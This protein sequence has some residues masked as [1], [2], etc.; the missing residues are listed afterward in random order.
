MPA[1]NTFSGTGIVDGQI[2][3]APHVSQ[4]V[5]AFTAQKDYDIVLSGS[6]EV[7]GSVNISGSLIKLN[8]N[9]AGWY[10]VYVTG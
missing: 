9:E 5:D 8:R 4:S 2:V 10:T 1:Q 6:L 3:E 7:T